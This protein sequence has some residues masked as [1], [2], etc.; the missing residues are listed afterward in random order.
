MSG[1]E[2]KP[3]ILQ[4]AM[5]PDNGKSLSLLLKD[6][7]NK[8]LPFSIPAESQMPMGWHVVVPMLKT[9]AF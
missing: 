1:K 8:L 4:I 2:I 5:R 6:N 3:F 9:A 7:T